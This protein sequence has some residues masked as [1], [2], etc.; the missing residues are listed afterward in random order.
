VKRVQIDPTKKIKETHNLNVFFFKKKGAN[1]THLFGGRELA[2]TGRLS[3][4]LSSSHL[5]KPKQ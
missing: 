1:L 2:V 5:D 4:E 3:L